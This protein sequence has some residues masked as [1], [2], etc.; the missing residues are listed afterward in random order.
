[1]MHQLALKDI[2]ERKHEISEKCNVSAQTR[3][4]YYHHAGGDELRI[5]DL[6]I[7]SPVYRMEN[8]RTQTKQR[9]YIQQQDLEADFFSS[10]Q[11]N[12]TA[13]RQQHVILVEFSKRGS[14]ETIKP[15]HATLEEDARQTEPLLI[16]QEGVV[17]NGNRRLAA[18]RDL[19]FTDPSR[20]ADFQLVQ[21]MVLP[22]GI[23]A[24]DIRRIEVRLQMRP[25][26]RLPYDW[27][28]E[29]LAVRDLVDRGITPSEIQSLMRLERESDVRTRTSRLSEAEIYLEEFLSAPGD[30][31][32]VKDQE[33]QFK[34]LETAIRR[35]SDGKEKDLARHMCHV[36]TKNSRELGTRAYD[37]KIAYGEKTYEVATRVASRL[38][39]SLASEDNIDSAEDDLFSDDTSSTEH[40]DF[41]SLADALSE[42]DKS[43]EHAE[44][45]RD[46]CEEVREEERE[47]DVGRK[48]VKAIGRIGRSLNAVSL[49]RAAPETFGE[50]L[51]GLEGI[52][53]RADAL[54][55]Q[56]EEP[57]SPTSA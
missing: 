8:Y 51:A 40:K 7:T 47:Q 44:V 34:E 25:E 13:Q 45:I 36:V 19:F 49:D 38:G 5:I 21:A 39:I 6:D 30:Y 1:M 41:S 12:I 32:A 22:A 3:M 26:T 52:K 14:G 11:E 54:I 50:I 55:S 57:E 16:T 33:Q 42:I 28:D 35:K 20:F 31:D 2:S 27:V 48:A 29:A 24:N 10:G 18:M 46:V 4:F 9:S 15:I 23:D 37:L 43:E 17:V 53:D 56:M